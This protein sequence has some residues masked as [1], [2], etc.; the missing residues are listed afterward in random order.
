MTVS[1]RCEQGAGH[2]E[3]RDTGFGM[4][5]DFVRERLF[6]PFESTKGP[7]GMGIGAYQVREYVLALGGEVR[8]SSQRGVGTRFTIV[9]P[10]EPDA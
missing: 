6:R 5:P 9:I 8:V 1:L 7:S 10:L 3:V 4:D 2:L